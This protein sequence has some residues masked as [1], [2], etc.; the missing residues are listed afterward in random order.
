[1][2]HLVIRRGLHMGIPNVWNKDYQVMSAHASKLDAEKRAAGRDTK[3]FRF[4]VI[5]KKAQ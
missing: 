2:I 1:M 5:S 3:Y 4:E